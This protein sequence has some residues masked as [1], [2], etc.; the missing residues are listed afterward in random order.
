[1]GR[2][3][4]RINPAVECIDYVI[5]DVALNYVGERDKSKEKIWKGEELVSIDTRF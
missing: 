4:S 5:A 2:R 3:S 1:M